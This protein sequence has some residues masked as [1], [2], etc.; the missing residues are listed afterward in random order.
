V[1]QLRQKRPEPGG[2]PVEWSSPIDIGEWTDECGETWWR[3]GG[4]PTTKRVE[5]PLA[6]SE[7][8]VRFVYLWYDHRDIAPDERPEF[9]ARVKPY[10]TERISYAPRDS[11]QTEYE[12][13]EFK[14]DLGESLLI[15][16]MS[17]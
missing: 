13:G 11:D 1:D 17:C 8:R 2:Q 16:E 10:L 9:W 15:V 4:R 6:N 12:I 5:H 7:V 3:R 14:N